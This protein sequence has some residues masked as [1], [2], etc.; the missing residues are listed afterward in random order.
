MLYDLQFSANLLA[1]CPGSCYRLLA[2][3]TVK[4][5]LVTLIAAG[6]VH[7]LLHAIMASAPL[8]NSCR[9]AFAYILKRYLGIPP[10]FITRTEALSFIWREPVGVCGLLAL[11]NIHQ[12]FG[13]NSAEFPRFTCDEACVFSS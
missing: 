3:G 5:S 7:S 2:K 1:I 8:F 6:E 10:A 4:V 11:P 12:I 13:D 9:Q